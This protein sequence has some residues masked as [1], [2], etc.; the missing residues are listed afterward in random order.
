MHLPLTSVSLLLLLSALAAWPIAAIRGRGL[1]GGWL[2]ASAR[3][4]VW[5]VGLLSLLLLVGLVSSLRGFEE[6]IYGISPQLKA[7]LLLP[8]VIV[9]LTSAAVLLTVPVWRKGCWTR[10]ARLYFT[11]LVAAAVAECWQFVYWNLV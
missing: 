6:L 8:R 11:A 5:G 4:L 3:A 7:V 1:G 10:N 9:A 2:G